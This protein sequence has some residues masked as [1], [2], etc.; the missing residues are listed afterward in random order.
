MSGL[1]IGGVGVSTS[2]SSYL[3]LK[4]GTIAT[5]KTLGSTTSMLSKIYLF[6]ILIMSFLGTT[7]GAI[8]GSLILQLAEST[9][10]KIFPFPLSL[11]FFIQPILISMT[12]GILISLIFSLI[13]LFNFCDMKINYLYRAHSINSRFEIPKLKQIFYIVTLILTLIIIILLLSPDIKLALWFIF[14]SIISFIILNLMSFIIKHASKSLVNRYKFHK[15]LSLKLALAS[16][17]SENGENKSVLLSIGIGLIILATMGQIEKNLQSVLTNDIP[18]KAPLYFLIDIQKNQKE[19]LISLLKNEKLIEAQRIEERTKYDIEMIKELGFC[20]GIENYSRYLSGRKEGESPPTLYEY[21]PEDAIVF[22]DESHVSLPQIK[23]MYRGDRSRKE[24]LTEY[25]FRLPS[26]LDNRPLRFDEWESI[27]GQKIFVSATPGEYEENNMEQKV[28]LIVRPTGLVDPTIEIRP[29][30][31]QVHDLMSEISEKVKKK[32]RVLETSIQRLTKARILQKL[33]ENWNVVSINR[34]AN[35]EKYVIILE[36]KI[37]K[38]GN[39]SGPIKLVYPRKA[40]GN[41]L[42]AKRSAIKAVL[43]SSPFPVP[44]ESFPRGLVLRVVFDPETNVGVN[45]G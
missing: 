11:G 25:G 33:N 16:V 9:L 45:N 2:V 43:E 20:S 34:L 26:A 42:I 29:A 15:M 28:D 19:D 12:L 17:G 8:T 5:L 7:M 37:D 18:K 24:T 35:Y 13:P 40:S 6:Q 38:N 1:V 30:T 36:L 21:L 32:E 39:I 4:R 27:S 23:G 14:G 41:F 3:N 10:I 44:K 22:V 31:N